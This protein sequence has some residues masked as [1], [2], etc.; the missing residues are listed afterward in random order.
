[1]YLP[2]RVLLRDLCLMAATLALW[3][4]SRELDAAQARAA[5]PV[6]IGAGIAATGMGFLAHEWGHLA[7]ALLSGSAVDYPRGIGSLFLFRF[8]D[9]RNTRRQ[10]LWMSSGG[11][12][13]SAGVVLLLLWLLS[14]QRLADR[15]ALGLT[16]L[17]VLAT[18]VL[19]VPG[20]WRAYR[21]GGQPGAAT[22]A[23]PQAP[24]R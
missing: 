11:F 21:G 15:V 9:G 12:V 3:A 20:A 24:R 23:G 5:L 8:D 16:G 18:L 19:E 10:F 6:A 1:M 14:P 17:G 2:W 22:L 4:L 13:A 7:G